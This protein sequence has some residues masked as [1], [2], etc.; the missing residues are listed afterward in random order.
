MAAPALPSIRA[1]AFTLLGM[2]DTSHS[3]IDLRMLQQ[4]VSRAGQQQP[5]QGP[6]PLQQPPVEPRRAARALKKL[7]LHPPPPV[8]AFKASPGPWKAGVAY[9]LREQSKFRSRVTFSP[10]EAHRGMPSL[11]LYANGRVQFM[12]AG[13]LEKAARAV[14]ALARALTRLNGGGP[15]H[16]DRTVTAAGPLRV[17]HARCMLTLSHEMDMP[18]LRLHARTQRGVLHVQ[19][20]T[21]HELVLKVVQQRVHVQVHSGTKLSVAGPSVDAI[22]AALREHVLPL[23]AAHGM[24]HLAAALDRAEQA[25]ARAE[26]RSVLLVANRLS[27]PLPADA[28]A[29]HVMAGRA[30][31][32]ASRLLAG[33]RADVAR[34]V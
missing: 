27:L 2:C 15:R 19:C 14:A 13:S 34:L 4:R 11:N 3:R 22:K 5:G 32:G 16:P 28:L 33:L 17:S 6:P 23:L 24:E 8:V 18:N 20:V 9:E 1:S 21:P 30:E 25:A 26:A 12:A 29:P 7:K 31:G 10:V